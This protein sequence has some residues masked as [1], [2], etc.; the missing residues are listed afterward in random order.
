MTRDKA[1]SRGTVLVLISAA[2]FGALAI[3]AKLA[4]AVGLTALTALNWRFILATLLMAAYLGLTGR[5]WRVK[6]REALTLLAL[7]GLGYAAQ[8]SLFFASLRYIPASATSMLLYTYP[9]LVSVLS[10][11]L[12]RTPLGTRHL[13]ALLAAGA[14]TFLLLWS[15]SLHLNPAG[16]A[17][18]L[19]AALVYSFYLLANQRLVRGVDAA[20]ASA[21]IMAGTAVT[22]T[23]T[24]VVQ[25]TFTCR[26]GPS[27][28]L[29]VTLMAAISTNIAIVTLLAG[30]RYVGA[31]AAS[32]LS[33]FEPVVTVALSVL[34]LGER[35]SAPQTVGGLLIASGV[36]LLHL[37]VRSR[38]APGRPASPVRA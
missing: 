38:P 17:L 10:F 32:V 35:L 12:W 26:L 8:S 7:G 19:G 6:P 28:W 27:A 5:S 24:N 3:F 4:Y 15:P 36:V 23:L 11:T 33:T 34:F 14:G 30:I 9:A 1:H 21:Y 25:G 29:A 2:A 37:P 13:L 16:T 22:F 18:G 20:V 31:E